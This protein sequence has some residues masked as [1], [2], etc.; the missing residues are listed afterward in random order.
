MFHV[1]TTFTCEQGARPGLQRPALSQ[2][3][4]DAAAPLGLGSAWTSCTARGHRQDPQP[5][6]PG[7]PAG[8]VPRVQRFSCTD[9]VRRR[10]RKYLRGI[11]VCSCTALLPK[12]VCTNPWG[13]QEE[14]DL[15]SHENELLC[16]LITTRLALYPMRIFVFNHS[17]TSFSSDCQYC[18]FSPHAFCSKPCFLIAFSVL[19]L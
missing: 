16:L 5:Q 12:D 9:E 6:L 17:V 2:A 11:P 19:L 10:A 3:V 8:C 4:G 1:F 14:Q 18:G 7:R 13:E 15:G